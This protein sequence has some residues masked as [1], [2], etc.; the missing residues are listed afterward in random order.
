MSADRGSDEASDEASDEVSRDSL[1]LFSAYVISLFSGSFPSALGVSL[2]G[3]ALERGLWRLEVISLDRFVTSPHDIDAPPFGGGAGL[4][5]RPE[6]LDA[7]LDFV[8]THH[9][10]NSRDYAYLV[11]SAKGERLTQ[12]R[13]ESLSGKRGLV[14]VCGRYQGIDQRFIDKR[15]LEE[16][17]IGDYILSGG[18]LA[19]MVVIESVVRLLPGVVGNRRSLLGESFAEDRLEAPSYT[20]PA[21]WGDMEV[22]KVLRSGHHG[23]IER[24][25]KRESD[26]LT[27]ER[28]SDLLKK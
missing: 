20:Q 3:R 10:T 11:M 21:R 18:E 4:V 7:A 16:V 15:G 17:S 9:K 12:R 5:M 28:R 19:S 25:R 8:E 14:I 26:R 6:P 13:V 24:W 22:P 23:R 1:G 27:R 2:V